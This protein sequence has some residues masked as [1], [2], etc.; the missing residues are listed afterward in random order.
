VV[1]YEKIQSRIRLLYDDRKFDQCIRECDYLLNLL[2]ED[3]NKLKKFCYRQIS[4]CYRKLDIYDKAMEYVDEAM[5]YATIKEELFDCLWHKGHIYRN[6]G[7]IDKAVDL[8]DQCLP[9]YKKNKM[10]NQV[11]GLLINKGSALKERDINLT[12]KLY[13]EAIECYKKDVETTQKE[14][15]YIYGLLAETCL[16]IRNAINLET[17]KYIRLISSPNKQKEL[18]AKLYHTNE[19]R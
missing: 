7:E 17:E 4:F 14:F 16:Y 2:G 12:K 9:F 15:D 13:E 3:D 10:Y 19:R 6:L 5:K 11:A 18:R 1:D 8:F